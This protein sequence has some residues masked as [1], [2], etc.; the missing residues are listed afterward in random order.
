MTELAGERCE[1]CHA[2]APK[3]PEAERPG[4]LAEIPEWELVEVNG[5]PRLRRAYRF[6][7]WEAALAFTVHVGGLAAAEDHHP[8]LRTEWGKV[9][10]TWWTHAIRDLH[11]NDFVMAAKC[12]EAH[13]K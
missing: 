8:S 6:P 1:A 4:L 7:S 11:R 12:D 10:V 2:G 9:T 13:A 5:T 3:V